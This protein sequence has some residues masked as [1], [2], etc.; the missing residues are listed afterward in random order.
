MPPPVAPDP[1]SIEELARLRRAL[2]ERDPALARADAA[3]KPLS[4]RTR[5]PGFATLIWMII[6]QQVSLASAEAVWLRLNAAVGEVTPGTVLALTDEAFRAVGFSRQKTRY[7][8]AIA[9]AGVDFDALSEMPLEAALTELTALTG[10]GRWTAEV[11]LLMSEG[12]LDAWPG[13]DIALQEAIRWAD[14]LEARPDTAATYARA[15]AWR[16]YRGVAAHLLWAWYL[17]VKTKRPL[18]LAAGGV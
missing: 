14:G 7:A 4:W 12:R 17:E 2:V 13:G 1:V 6:G 11:Y 8:K 18:P 9:A 16:P 10:V 5:P 3:A 15:E